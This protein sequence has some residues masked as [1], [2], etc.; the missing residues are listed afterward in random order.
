MRYRV[1]WVAV[2]DFQTA[3]FNQRFSVG[4]P[5]GTTLPYVTV[6][7]ATQTEV[8]IGEINIV[9]YQ[10]T[11]DFYLVAANTTAVATNPIVCDYIRLEPVN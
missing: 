4:V 3:T 2:N 8:L 7:L 11:M 5:T 6:P 10:N 1:Y 9:N